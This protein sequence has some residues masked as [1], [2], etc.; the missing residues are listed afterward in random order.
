[1]YFYST[2]NKQIQTIGNLKCLKLLLYLISFRTLG[3]RLGFGQV[4]VTNFIL[5]L[6]KQLFTL[7]G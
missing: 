7:H 5:I 1:M 3:N 4:K 6:N 2:A